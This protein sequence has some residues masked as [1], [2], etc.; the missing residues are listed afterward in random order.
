MRALRWFFVHHL[1]V[2]HGHA[3]VM[4]MVVY[5]LGAGVHHLNQV[6]KTLKRYQ[7]WELHVEINHRINLTPHWMEG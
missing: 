5:A 1:I 2:V 3:V 4:G 7:G 6:D